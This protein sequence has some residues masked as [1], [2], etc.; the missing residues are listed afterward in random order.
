MR[1][2]AHV[3]GELFPERGVVGQL[4]HL[5]LHPKSYGVDG[6]QPLLYVGQ[7]HLCFLVVAPRV[8][9]RLL[10]IAVCAP[11]PPTTCSVTLSIGGLQCSADHR[12]AG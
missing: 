10:G 5:H 1:E 11:H 7:A 8:R 4:V 6:A 12:L 9:G 3:L 2:G